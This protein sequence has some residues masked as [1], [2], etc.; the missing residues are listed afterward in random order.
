VEGA[1]GTVLVAGL[2]V[3]ALETGLV[4]ES[5]SGMCLGN[6]RDVEPKV[7]QQCSEL[8]KQEEWQEKIASSFSL[9]G[10]RSLT[11]QNCPLMRAD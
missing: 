8:A 4:G 9:W 10:I 3:L 6:S 5:R 11:A 7:V 1:A 2:M